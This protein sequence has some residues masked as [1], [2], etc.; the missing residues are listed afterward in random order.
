MKLI[1]TKLAGVFIL[2]P[3]IFQDNRGYFTETYNKK[4]FETLGMTGNFIQ[5]NQSKSLAAGTIRGLHFQRSPKAQTKIVRCITG[6][7]YDIA[8]DLRKKSPTYGQW[9][10]VTLSEDNHRQLVIPKGFAHGFCTLRPNTVVAYKVDEYY[11]GEAD[12][13]IHWNDKAL[14]IDWPTSEPIL[15]EK[16][17]Q[18]PKLSDIESSL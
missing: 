9:V 10:G 14:A 13:G 17:K 3:K 16:D 12:G 7:I 6:A 15:S 1:P 4:V 2:E 11:C 18:L 8:V 5:D